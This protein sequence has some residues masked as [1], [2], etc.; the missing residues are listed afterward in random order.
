[1]SDFVAL[2]LSRFQAGKFLCFTL[3]DK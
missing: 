2:L 3:L 1:M